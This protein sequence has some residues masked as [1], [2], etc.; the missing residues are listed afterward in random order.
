MLCSKASNTS[1][2]D[3]SLCRASVHY[4]VVFLLLSRLECIL[5]TSHVVA[6][7]FTAVEMEHACWMLEASHF[8]PAY[9]QYTGELASM[10]SKTQALHDQ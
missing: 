4:D 2:L 8:A 1:D 5:K 6:R 3:V 9:R 10:V 7:V